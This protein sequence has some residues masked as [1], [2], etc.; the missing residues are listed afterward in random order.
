HSGNYE[1]IECLER[2]LLPGLYDAHTHMMEYGN[3]RYMVDLSKARSVEELMLSLD[4]IYSGE[5]F[6]ELFYWTGTIWGIGYDDSNY[7]KPF[8]SCLNELV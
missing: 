2:R 1:K 8:K 5:S 3:E 4:H 6:N 7:S